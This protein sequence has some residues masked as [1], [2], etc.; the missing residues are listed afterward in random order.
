MGAASSSTTVDDITNLS[1][2]TFNNVSQKCIKGG[3]EQISDI[4]LE[5]VHNSKI[6]LTDISQILK[7]DL[8]CMLSSEL[9]T[10]LDSELQQKMKQL[11]ESTIKNY[12]AGAFSKSKTLI[13]DYTDLAMQISNNIKSSCL[14][15]MLQQFT[16]KLKDASDVNLVA[17]NMQQSM[18]ITAQ[19]I[20][21]QVADS[22]S[23]NSIIQQFDQASKAT[24]SGLDLDGIIMLIALIIVGVIILVVG[25]PMMS[26]GSGQEASPMWKKVL[27]G[28]FVIG[29][30]GLLAYFI[31]YMTRKPK[32]KNTSQDEKN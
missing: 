30:I 23:Y 12:P 20:Q 3:I 9:Q 31:Y 15:R 6:N 16:I 18:D 11:A 5:N 10:Q 14:P 19:C 28:V 17:T 2:K 26:G 29:F 1:M 25:L 21:N 27:I 24:A 13:K 7:L 32:P 4:N 8:N 22:A